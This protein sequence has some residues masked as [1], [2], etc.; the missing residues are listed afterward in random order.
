MFA[1]YVPDNYRVHSWQVTCTYQKNTISLRFS[2]V[3]RITDPT[4]KVTFLFLQIARK[5]GCWRIDEDEMLTCLKMS[6]P[7][8]LTMAGKID[9]MLILGKGEDT[10]TP[11]FVHK[12]NTGSDTNL[13]NLILL[14]RDSLVFSQN[15]P[16]DQFLWVL[17]RCCH[18]HARAL[19]SG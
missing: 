1:R 3:M 16:D 7:V 15:S 10:N 8:G 5:V 6:D 4:L 17:L 12:P 2:K 11:S 13:S 14:H 19:P 9:I 18:G